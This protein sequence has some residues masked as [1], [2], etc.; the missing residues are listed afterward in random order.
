MLLFLI[1][2]CKIY[3]FVTK[4]TDLFIQNKMVVLGFYNLGVGFGIDIIGQDFLLENI[5]LVGGCQFSVWKVKVDVRVGTSGKLIDFVGKLLM[6][7]VDVGL[8]RQESGQVVP[9]D[10]G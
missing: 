3:G 7:H 10:D 6:I 5:G 1:P 2:E 4:G 8:A 9:D